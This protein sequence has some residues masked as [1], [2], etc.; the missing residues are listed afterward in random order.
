MNSE[1]LNIKNS[2][3]LNL[4][5]DFYKGNKDSII[6]MSHGF[7]GDR[8]EWGRNTKN[9]LSFQEEGYNVLTFDFSGCGESDDDSL[10]VAKQVD[11]LNCIIKFISKEKIS[12]IC[13]FGHSL[14]GLVS[15]ICYSP[16]INCIILSAPITNKREGYLE[17]KFSK[18]QQ[19]ELKEK[20]Y[21]TK[22]RDEGVRRKFIIDQQMIIDRETVD[23]EEILSNIDCPVLI[24][25]GK[26]D[27]VVPVNDSISAMHYLNDQAKLEIIENTGHNFEGSVKTRG[28]LAINWLK[29]KF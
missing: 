22:V 2:R 19:N 6:V 16:I 9:A 14:G 12:N 8:H 27:E 23:Q 21:I 29:N 11:D 3:N 4:I 18:D 13:L 5:A 7:T 20:G 25:H 26:D 17:Y 1:R 15:L 24:I 28:N 10:T